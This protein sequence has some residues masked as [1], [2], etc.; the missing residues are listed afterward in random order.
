M[1]RPDLLMRNINLLLSRSLLVGELFPERVACLLSRASAA[2]DPT[3][4]L[5]AITVSEYGK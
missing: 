2:I 4:P 1:Y 5:E 3:L